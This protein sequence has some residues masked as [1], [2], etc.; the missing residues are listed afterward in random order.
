MW[1]HDGAMGWGWGVLGMVWMLVFWVMIIGLIA[2]AVRQFSGGRR[3]ESG[4]SESP[5]EIAQKR[6]ARGEISREEFEE[7]R[8]TLQR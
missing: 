1:M 2:W 3:G 6:L 5:L 8:V 7:L 4:E